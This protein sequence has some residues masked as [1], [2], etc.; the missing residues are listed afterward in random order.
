MSKDIRVALS[1]FTHHKTK[2]LYKEFGDSGIVSLWKLWSYCAVHQQDGD[3]SNWDE[4]L[5]Q[6]ACERDTDC[7]QFVERLAS[8]EVSFL[9]KV[10]GKY[11]IHDW[12]EHQPWVFFAK[13]RSAISRENVKKRWENKGINTSCI[14]S[15]KEPYTIGNTPLPFPLPI[16][17]PNQ[18][19][20]SSSGALSDHSW[21]A[22]IELFPKRNG[23]LLAL[24]AARE[25]FDK[26]PSKWNQWILSAK[27]YSC[28]ESVQKGIGICN[29]KTFLESTWRDWTEPEVVG[30]PRMSAA[31][32][33][34][35]QL[36]M[37]KKYKESQKGKT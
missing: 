31:Q 25:V 36:E 35:P 27:Y 15:V 24:E 29:P 11:S 12:R 9:D 22:F 1:F 2:R 4:T 34:N 37:I 19:S 21:K 33:G 32:K 7:M 28:S 8:K 16:P 26:E 5:F 23:K 18:A 3:L 13:E 17:S 30:P 6:I 20:E 14:P 10:D